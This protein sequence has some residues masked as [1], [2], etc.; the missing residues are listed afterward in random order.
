M[1]VN[2]LSLTI[3]CSPRRAR[4]QI[5]SRAIR[6]G[7]CVTVTHRRFRRQED[8]SARRVDGNGDGWLS[9]ARG[10]VR[11]GVPNES[12]QE[13]IQL[14]RELRADGLS[15]RKIS[16]ELDTRGIPTKSGRKWNRKTVAAILKRAA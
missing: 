7:N 16:R 4:R 9:P 8:F 11:V 2:N 5:P 10:G 12:E 6:D 1:V 13:A 3:W 15:Y 14:I